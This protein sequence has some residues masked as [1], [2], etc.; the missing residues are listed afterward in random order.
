MSELTR[1]Q[2][3][4][5]IQVAHNKRVWPDFS[6][7]NLRA[8][9]LA[10][11]DLSLADFSGTNLREAD[12]R[13]AKLADTNFIEAN[14]CRANLEKADLRNSDLIEA[15]LSMANLNGVD[16]SEANLC[17]ANLSGAT[18]TYS[19]LQRAYL[20]RTHF[21]KTNLCSADLNDSE[22]GFTT[23]GDIDLSLVKHLDT[24]RHRGPSEIGNNTLILTKGKIPESFLR[25]CGL[26]DIQIEMAKLLNSALTREQFRS[27]ANRI[28]SS[29]TNSS[30]QYYSCFLSYSHDDEKFVQRLH[31]DLQQRGVRCWFAP[32]DMKIGDKIRFRIDE[33]IRIHD[34]LLLVL[35]EHSVASQWVDHEVEHALDLEN[36]RQKLV[37][38]PIRLDEAVMQS[39]VGWAGNIRRTRHV[40]DFS[41]W[42]DHDAY[43]QAFERLL[44]DLKAEG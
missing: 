40:G 44:R 20:V 19:H 39:K 9:K 30:I 24:V 2:V 23:F 6:L 37:L 36:E 3:L 1:E 22:I 15:D 5:I 41:Q 33:S 25:G 11:L 13:G 28:S 42:K 35:S 38:F 17:G 12:L 31:A 16:L 34:K 8:A 4:Q 7:R 29:L 10:N 26:S 18:L 27:I 43:Q 21:L 14:L 32:E